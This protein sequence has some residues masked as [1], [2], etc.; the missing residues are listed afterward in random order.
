M[1]GLFLNTPRNFPTLAAVIPNL[2]THLPQH[3]FIRPI[4]CTGYAA[5]VK[6][7]LPFLLM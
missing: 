7:S 5:A 3:I 2:F 6:Y 4:Q 1:F